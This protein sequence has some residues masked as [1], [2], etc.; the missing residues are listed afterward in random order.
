MTSEPLT[1]VVD[2]SNCDREPIHIPGSILPHG[3]MLV[4]D[5]ASFAIVQ[6]AGDTGN[7]LGVE[8]AAL[9]DAPLCRLLSAEQIA[10]LRSLIDSS[11]LTRPR[12]M[13]DPLLR[14]VPERPIDASVHVSDGA[15]VIEVEDA[16]L[17]HP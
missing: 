7:L 5:P 10:R 16:D 9:I 3:A 14:V 2:L 12:H 8:T 17:D 13:L 1:D 15:L 11:P 4:V 6:V